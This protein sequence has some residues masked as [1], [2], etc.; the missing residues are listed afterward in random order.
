MKLSE[1]YTLHGYVLQ[2][3]GVRLFGSTAVVRVQPYRTATAGTA[4]MD[5]SGEFAVVDVW[6]KDGGDWKLSVRYLSRPDK[7]K[8]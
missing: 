8:P 7:L 1:L 5:R 3:V 6:T 2:H 4:A